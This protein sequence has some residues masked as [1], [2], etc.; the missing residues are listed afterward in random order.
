MAISGVWKR[1]ATAVVGIPA[2]LWLVLDGP[3][4]LFGALVV[5][6]GAGATW[7]LARMFTRAERA[8]HARV[9][10]G[11]TS[12]VIASF[13][14][15]DAP[16]VA[17]ALALLVVLSV[18]LRTRTAQSVEAAAT[19]VLTVTY[20]GWLLGHAVLLR[21]LPSGAPLV[22]FLVGVTWAGESAAYAV[23]STIG[24]H[25]LAPI[26]SPGKTIEGSVGQLVASLVAAPLLAA[27]LLPGWSTARVLG[28]AL[29]L[30]VL[31]QVGDLAESTIKRSL[32][33]KDTGGLIPGH[34]GIL[35]RLDSVLFNAPALFYY[36]KLVGVGA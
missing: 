21:A 20:V 24:R 36:V 7:E 23:G 27:W 11:A 33:T 3:T 26:I 10:T 4:V 31:G 5:M 14:V 18:S 29:V 2:F 16:T 9:A 25:K 30:A 15:P 6:L 13:L 8:T 17:L 34:G 35:D 22:I 28:G 32:G 1:L 12:V 19:T